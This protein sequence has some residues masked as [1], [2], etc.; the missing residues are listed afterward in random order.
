MILA[1]VFLCLTTVLSPSTGQEPKG[2]DAL[3][4][5]REDQQKLIVDTHNAFRRAVKPAASN[6]MKMEWSPS[7]AKNAQNWANQCTL[8]HSP[9]NLRTTN[10]RCGENLF[11][12]SGP[13]PWSHAMQV[14]HNEVK[15]FEY[16]TGEKTPRAVIGHYTQMV[17]HS[18]HEIGCGV[19][20]CPNSRYKYFY[21]CH[22]CPQGN[23][24]SSIPKPYKAGEPCG[25]CPNACEDGLCTNPCKHQDF[26][27]NCRNL[28]MLFGCNHS[29]VKEKCRASCK[30]TT[31]IV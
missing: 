18:S 29:L 19:A 20:L 11:M 5:L 27:A 6:M 10:V 12:S 3:S 24:I 31:Q 13:S 23:I 28:K 4:T 30:C 15:D 8:R 25:D 22:Y 2:L 14:W 9:A 17:W 26:F 16:G 7:A 21:V 1:V